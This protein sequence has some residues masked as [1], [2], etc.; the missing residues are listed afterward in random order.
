MTAYR[1]ISGTCVRCQTPFAPEQVVVM[2]RERLIAGE[3]P[4]NSCTYTTEWV[5]VCIGCATG[6]E[7]RTATEACNCQGCAQPMMVPPVLWY[8]GRAVCSGRCEQRI[9]RRVQ[10]RSQ[11]VCD[12]C[13]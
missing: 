8:A 5:T 7:Q 10:Y 1:R 12:A 11:L 4:G 3:L 2:A 13:G 6:R 9:R